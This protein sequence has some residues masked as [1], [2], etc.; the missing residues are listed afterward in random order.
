MFAGRDCPGFLTAGIAKGRRLV[1]KAACSAREA[2]IKGVVPGL[3]VALAGDCGPGGRWVAGLCR[4]PG[5]HRDES[6]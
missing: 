5:G 6:P 2:M 3:L 4:S 1:A